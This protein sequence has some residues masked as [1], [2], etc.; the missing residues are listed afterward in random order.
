MAIAETNFDHLAVIDLETTGLDPVTGLILEVGVVIVDSQLH[1]VA[2]L[3]VLV[4]DPR[5]VEWA[6]RARARAINGAD[7]EFAERMHLDNGLVHDLLSPRQFLGEDEL[8]PPVHRRSVAFTV[9]VAEDGV[10]R[11]LEEQGI[12]APVP[13]AGSS[14]RALDGPFLEAH[15]PKLFSRF[16]HRTVDAS[17]L[18]EF[19]RFVDPEG[20]TAMNTSVPASGHRSL[21]DCQRSIKIMRLFADHYGVRRGTVE[22][23]RCG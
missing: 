20:Y 5:A 21:G 19:A 7:L 18:T 17:A 2:Q 9:D 8:Q 22:S 12:S 14:V 23:G 15:M 4:A 10:I 3:E 11:F 13:L 16:T 1:E 6:D